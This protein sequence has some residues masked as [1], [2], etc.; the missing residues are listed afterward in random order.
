MEPEENEGII[1]F[2]INKYEDSIK[3]EKVSVKGLKSSPPILKFEGNIYNKNIKNCL[4]IWPQDNDTE[5]FFIARI[6]KL[7]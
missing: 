4:R 6:R 5:G 7:Q 3:I 1:D 2:I